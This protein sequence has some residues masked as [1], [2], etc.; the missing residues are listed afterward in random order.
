MRA[1]RRVWSI[2]SAAPARRRARRWWSTRRPRHQLYR[3]QRGGLPRG[4]A[5]R[6]HFQAGFAGDGRQERADRYGRR[7]PGT[8]F[9]RRA[10]GLLRDDRA[11]AARRPAASCCRRA[12][13]TKFT[14]EFVERAKKLKVGNGLDESVEVGPQVNPSQIETSTK[15]VAIALAEGAK[16]LAGGHALD[17]RELCRTARSLS[18]RCWVELLRTCALR[19]KKFSGR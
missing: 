2:S 7:Q 1:C 19:A 18:R 12:L 15:Y 17:R 10:V 8:G 4:P 5:R 3:V 16:L 9:G 6:G 11:S 13:P 14:A